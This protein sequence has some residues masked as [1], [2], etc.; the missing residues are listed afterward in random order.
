[1]TLAFDDLQVAANGIP[2]Q[3][4]RTYDNKDKRVGDFGIG[5]NLGVRNVRVEKSVSLGKFWYQSVD[6][7]G[8]FPVYAAIT[9]SP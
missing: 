6:N 9:T 3:V 8:F 5:W 2:I 1:M 7:S 4:Q